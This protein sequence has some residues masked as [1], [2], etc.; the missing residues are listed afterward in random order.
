MSRLPEQFSRRMQEQLGAEYEDF[1]A[2][3]DQ[4]EYAGLR[5]NTGKISVEHFLSITPFHLEPVPWTDNG[6]YYRK[7]EPV[8]KHPHYFAGLYYIQEPSAMLPASRLPVC[9]GET[10][11][12]LCAAPGGKA[13]ELSSR[14]GRDGLLIANDVSTSRAKALV[15]NLTVWG[16]SN[17]CITGETPQ[18]LLDTFGCSFDKILVDAPCSGEGMF[19]KDPGLIDSW[20]ERGPQS[21]APLQKEILTCAA[22]MLKPGGMMVYSTCTFS[23][24]EDESVIEAILERRP[25][26]SLVQPPVAEGFEQGRHPLEACIRVWPHRVHG[27]GHFLALMKKESSGQNSDPLRKTEQEIRDSWK[28]APEEVRRFLSLIP[29]QIWKNSCFGQ[30]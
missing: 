26:L 30:I 5:V 15:K 6:F 22:A 20:R 2:C 4:E 11:L 7:E 18:K 17:C 24:E 28:K 25:D 21:Y 1:L 27:E 23:E 3:F 19:R 10:V 9:S 29:E 12:D 13:T 14:L 8:T 16:T